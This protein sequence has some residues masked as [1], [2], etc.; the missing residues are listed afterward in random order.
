[1]IQV[2]AILD[3]DLGHI[4]MESDENGKKYHEIVIMGVKVSTGTNSLEYLAK[5]LFVRYAYLVYTDH[6]G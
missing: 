2:D 6:A 3:F 5:Q 4:R 1:M